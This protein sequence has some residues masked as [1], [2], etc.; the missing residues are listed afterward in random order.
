MIYL[1]VESGLPEPPE[2]R[3]QRVDFLPFDGIVM[4]ERVEGERGLLLDSWDPILCFAFCARGKTDVKLQAEVGHV[5]HNLE[6]AAVEVTLCTCAGSK[7]QG[8]APNTR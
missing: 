2:T 4:P 3:K 6:G 5:S 7:T 1:R 8:R